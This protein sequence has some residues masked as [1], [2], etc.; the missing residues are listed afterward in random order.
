MAITKEVKAPKA[1][2]KKSATKIGKAKK[3]EAVTPSNNALVTPAS[4]LAFSRSIEPTDCFFHQKASNQELS[5]KPVLV[6]KMS[7]RTTMSNRQKPALAKDPEKLNA[8][9]IK[10]NLQSTEVCYLDQDYDQ[11]VAKFGLKILPMDGT[12]ATCNSPTMLA[13][14]KS[15]VA[16]YKE[17][18]QF[19]ELAQRYA[20]NIANARWLW[21]NR[22]GAQ[23]ITTSVECI[24]DGTHHGIFTFDSKKISTANPT[25]D[26]E[27]VIKL[28]ELIAAALRGDIFLTLYVAAEVSIGYG[29]QVFP[30]EEMNLDDNKQGKE[31]FQRNGMTGYHSVKVG[32]AL[33]TIDT[34]YPN[35]KDEAERMVIPIEPFGSV[36]TLGLAFRQPKDSA[37]F[38]TIF[39]KWMEEGV[40]PDINQQHFIMASFIRGGIFGKSSK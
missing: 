6:T 34:W 16:D 14:L 21:R 35:N 29:H 39:D 9:I 13:K 20:T 8:E 40:E 30:S 38:Y 17:R 11:L 37:D 12:P 33:R 10:A 5:S 15:V 2:A 27:Q 26:N 36:T 4:V 25:S 19:T 22:L 3:S 28:S 1:T 31:L 32:N 18:T 7:L 24:V 23:S